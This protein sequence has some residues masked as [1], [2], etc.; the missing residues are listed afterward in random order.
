MRSLLRLAIL[1]T[2][3]H[4]ASALAWGAFNANPFVQIRADIVS[5]KVYNPYYEPI[6]CRGFAFG[7]TIRG[8]VIRAEFNDIIPAGQHRIAYAYTFDVWNRFVQGWADVRCSF[9]R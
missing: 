6:Q 5:A 4:S 8:N 2:L 9:L 3:A 1:V 7:R